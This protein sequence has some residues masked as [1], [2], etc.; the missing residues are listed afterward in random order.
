MS[1][2]M[3][4]D[5]GLGTTFW[6][7]LTRID[8]AWAEQVRQGGCADCGGPLDRSDYPRK[9]RGELGEAADE[10]VRRVST[11]PPLSYWPEGF[12]EPAAGGA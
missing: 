10:Y 5:W 12:G 6:Q 7:Q 1:W 8:L 4:N 2:V 9:P 11:T 3:S